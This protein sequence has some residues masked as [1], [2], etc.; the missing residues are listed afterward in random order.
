MRLIFFWVI[1]F[2]M[3]ISYSQSNKEN[4]ILFFGIS[5][6]KADEVFDSMDKAIQTPENVRA[7][8]LSHK[9][10]T[11]LP[12]GF[13]KLINLEAVNLSYNQFT[14]IPEELLKSDIKYIYLNG[15]K[16]D[17]IT[18]NTKFLKNKTVLLSGNPIDVEGQK[19]LSQKKINVYYSKYNVFTSEGIGEYPGESLTFEQALV[20]TTSIIKEL[21]SFTA[22]ACLEPSIY[23]YKGI[24]YLEIENADFCNIEYML[25]NFIELTFLSITSS[26]INLSKVPFDRLL[27]LKDIY[28]SDIP[29]LKY[30]PKLIYNIE[31]LERLYLFNVMVS[32]QE[33]ERFEKAMPNCEVIR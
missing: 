15:N 8:D 11:E 32:D 1:F 33:I 7:I 28:L 16:I 21:K 27:G 24:G 20:D 22:S 25:G 29:N 18:F 23:S 17:K 13:E 26:H 14:S 9:N 12:F 31:G 5:N 19:K 10:L 4:K 6:L 3:N 2:Q 30:L